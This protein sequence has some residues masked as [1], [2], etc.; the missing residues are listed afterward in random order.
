MNALLMLAVSF[1]ILLMVGFPI[2]AAVGLSSV[3]YL[4]LDGTA[5]LVLIPQKIVSSADNFSMLALPLFM[6]MG[7]LMNSGGITKVILNFAKT[8]IGHVRGGLLYVTTVASM[9]FASMCGSSAATAASIGGMMIPALRDDGYDDDLIGSVVASG[10]CLGPIIPPSII[11]VIYA[12]ISGDSIAKL[13]LGGAIPG[14]LMGLLYM[15]ISA[16]ICKKRGYEL[17]AKERAPMKEVMKAF[18]QALPSLAIPIISMGGILMGV[19]TATEGGAIASAYA[20]ILSIINREM[21]VKKFVT[22]LFNAAKQSANV[23][24]IMGT[25][26][27]LGWILT[28]N[29]VPQMLTKML[30]GITSN[31]ILLMFII[32]GFILF[33]GCFLTEATIVPVL[34]PL[35]LPVIKQVGF[36]PIAFGVILCSISVAGALTPPVGGMLFV[37]S[38]VGNIPVMSIAKTV[39]PYLGVITFVLLLCSV[40]PGIVSFLPNLLIKV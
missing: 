10:A 38:S 14:V 16:R 15:L 1:L 36:D 33:L 23:M 26:A 12:S 18:F 31:P 7:E 9:I 17:Q 25:G 11:L 4:L 37:T 2:F 39:L 40:F 13:F 5:P 29:Q 3:I 22:A 28:K 30:I 20:L 21:T 34:A 32:I 6:L 35:L 24:L 27:T 19:F 8:V